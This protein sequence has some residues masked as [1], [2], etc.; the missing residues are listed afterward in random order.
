MRIGGH[1]VIHAG[2]KI[3]NRVAIQD[4]AI[5]GKRFRLGALSSAPRDDVP[6]TVLG[7]DSSVLAGAVVFAGAELGA[8][9]IAGDQS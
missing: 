9:T 5:V 4:G 8:G 1:V 6:P 7:D 3:G 2:T